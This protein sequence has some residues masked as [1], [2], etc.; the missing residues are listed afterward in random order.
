MGLLLMIKQANKPE[1]AF[2]R[3][4]DPWPGALA[5]VSRERFPSVAEIRNDYAGLRL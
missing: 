3:G 2:W 4:F 5:Q 1:L